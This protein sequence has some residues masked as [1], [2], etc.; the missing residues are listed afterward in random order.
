ME[1]LLPKATFLGPREAVARGRDGADLEWG[2]VDELPP[3][4]AYEPQGPELEPPETPAAVAQG[5]ET[6]PSFRARP[7]GTRG[8]DADVE[9]VSDD[10]VELLEERQDVPALPVHSV[11]ADRQGARGCWALSQKT[12][13]PC[14]AAAIRGTDYCA[15]HSGIGVSADP[16]AYSPLAHQRRR[17]NLAVRA[18]M[19]LALGVTRHT[20]PRAVLRARAMADSE[21]LA[22]AAIDGAL[23]NGA[24]ALKVIREVDP[25]PQASV[26]VSIPRTPEDVNAL[27]LEELRA[28][29]GVDPSRPAIEN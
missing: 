6:D 19:R 25:A 24:L 3:I 9:F 16:A 15:A 5:P 12:G 7:E 14:G 26:S 4:E 10:E 29:L 28:L 13:E 23:K 22:A 11:R 21:R 8:V 1:P 17:E 2:E 27:G 20:G 18:R